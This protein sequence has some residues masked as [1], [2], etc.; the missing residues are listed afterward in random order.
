LWPW[1]NY[2]RLCASVTKQYNFLPA[3]GSDVF[4]WQ[5]NCS[6]VESNG[7][8]PPGLLLS[9]AGWLPR[10]RDELRTQ[11]SMGLLY[12]LVMTYLNDI[13]PTFQC[14]CRSHARS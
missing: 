3:K 11:S 2:L 6:L 10:N 13:P 4:G 1:A 14:H 9:S 12:F 7:S 5:S 8:L